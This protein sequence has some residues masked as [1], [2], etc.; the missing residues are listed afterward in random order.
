MIWICFV[1]R[2]FCLFW[3][4]TPKQRAIT[5]FQISFFLCLWNS[6]F[7]KDPTDFLGAF[8]DERISKFPSANLAPKFEFKRATKPRKFE[9]REG[10]PSDFGTKNGPNFDA[11]CA[12]AS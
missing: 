1:L 10:T 3:G 5:D 9:A 4:F 6:N 7:F 12:C 11:G 8:C 2:C